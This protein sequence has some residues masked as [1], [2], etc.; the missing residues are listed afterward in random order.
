MRLPL[1]PG[2]CG[3][4][5]PR[6]AFTVIEL[7]IAIALGGMVAA[8]AFAGV[9]LA[10]QAVTATSQLSTENAMIRAGMMSSF[11]ELDWWHAYD[12]PNSSG[13]QPL[14]DFD[15]TLGMG[16]PFTKMNDLWP[17]NA[18]DGSDGDVGWERAYQWPAN[19]PRT[20]W[21]GNM[22][23]R[24]QSTGIEGWYGLFANIDDAPAYGISGPAETTP[25]RWRHRQFRGLSDVLGYYGLIDYLP[26]NA[27]YAYYKPAD[28][29]WPT[30]TNA[31]GIPLEFMVDGMPAGHHFLDGDGGTDFPRCLYRSSHVSSYPVLAYTDLTKT[32]TRTMWFEQQRERNYTGYGA[33]EFNLQDMLDRSAARQQL[34]TLRPTHWPAVRLTFHRS[35]KERRFLSLCQIAWTSPVTGATAQ[36]S[37]AG[38]GSTLRGARQ[39]RGLD[40]Y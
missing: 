32:W 4:S 36:L 30:L 14:R 26:A 34:I 21:R 1:N 11:D 31:G 23:E 9:R 20:W 2:R 17:K 39:Q 22:A 29:A 12:S 8:I 10:G 16:L 7:L 24:S 3:G 28:A 15:S 5:T 37:F 35:I 6:R 38:F 27:V 19:D 18:W 13:P 40:D 25:H 33:N